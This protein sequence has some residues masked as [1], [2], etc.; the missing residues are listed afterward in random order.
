MQNQNIMLEK[1]FILLILSTL[2]IKVSL[3]VHT[4][5]VK[6]KQNKIDIGKNLQIAFIYSLKN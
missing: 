6:T 1:Y 3:K 5:I 2:L 4:Y